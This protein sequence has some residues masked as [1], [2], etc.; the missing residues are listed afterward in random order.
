M[1][2]G[3]KTGPN[4]RGSM[5]GR[6]M[7]YCAGFQTPGFINQEFGRGRG[8][9]RGFGLRR[10]G[11]APVYDKPIELTKKEKLKILEADKKD[12]ETELKEI[13]KEIVELKK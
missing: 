3:D 11:V 10:F 6:G 2:R 8:C 1:P 12:I 9:G 5:T 7:G 4:G 13:E